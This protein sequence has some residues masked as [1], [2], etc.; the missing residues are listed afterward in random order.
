MRIER[1][2][3]G[4]SSCWGFLFYF[5]H[6]KLEVPGRFD[7][8]VCW[9]AVRYSVLMKDSWRILYLIPW[10]FYLWYSFFSVFI[11]WHN[12]KYCK[13]LSY[14]ICGIEALH[15]SL[16]IFVHQSLF[17]FQWEVLFK[18]NVW[19]KG[20]KT[21]QYPN[22]PSCLSICFIILNTDIVVL[23]SF[24]FIWNQEVPRTSSNKVKNHLDQSNKDIIWNLTLFSYKE[25]FNLLWFFN[26]MGSSPLLYPKTVYGNKCANRT[27]G[28]SSSYSKA[29]A[30][31]GQCLTQQF[32]F[33]S[34]WIGLRC[35]LVAKKKKT[36]IAWSLIEEGLIY[37]DL[38]SVEKQTKSNVEMN[39][40]WSYLYFIIRFSFYF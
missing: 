37:G 4:N 24:R 9:W 30:V 10:W 5:F 32:R 31:L 12:I 18:K 27:V 2:K 23:L 15:N 36:Q 26:I 7:S 25:Y 39:T 1:V 28:N 34:D 33:S 29:G 14:C 20:I 6:T 17:Q 22:V 35:P 21:R 11:T 16:Y 40:L 38:A 8:S 13:I 19:P 3:K